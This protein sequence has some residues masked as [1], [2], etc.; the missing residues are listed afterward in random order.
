MAF[1]NYHEKFR[2]IGT[3]PNSYESWVDSKA[4][5]SGLERLRNLMKDIS[6]SFNHGDDDSNKKD[7]G[8]NNCA[9][10]NAV[11][12]IGSFESELSIEFAKNDCV[13]EQNNGRT[14]V[15]VA[16]VC[17]WINEKRPRFVKSENEECMH[18][19]DLLEVKFVHHL[20]NVHRL[21]VLVYTALYALKVN[22][23]NPRNG[24][25]PN[26]GSYDD[27]EGTHLTIDN[28]Q[29]WYSAGDDCYNSDG[30]NDN[31]IGNDKNGIQKWKIDGCR[32]MLY[33]ARTGEMEVC[34]IQAR[35]AMD[36]LLDISQFKYNGKDRKNLQLGH[37]GVVPKNQIK[38]EK[39]FAA[40]NHSVSSSHKC[41][42]PKKRLIKNSGKS[43]YTPLCIDDNDES[44]ANIPATTSTGNRSPRTYRL[45]KRSKKCP[46]VTPPEEG[47]D[48]DPI[49]LD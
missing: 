32:G 19:V 33:N 28:G 38:Q 34:S 5:I 43:Y 23:Y 6:R 40:S 22:N 48:D 20:S 31:P 24:G 29:D 36:F 45:K 4:L 13:T 8:N 10:G 39:Y 16:G 42:L 17:D 46:T 14:I 37:K 44:N 15:G 47:T 2:Q 18:N 26:P 3:D 41:K 12:G 25:D 9:N 21:Q 7:D 11:D 49:V 35:N 27:S 30:D 1:S